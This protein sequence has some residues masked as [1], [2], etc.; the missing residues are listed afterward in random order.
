MPYKTK[1]DAMDIRCSNSVAALAVLITGGVCAFFVPAASAGDRIEFSAP[2]VPLAVPQAEVEAKSPARFIGS[3]GGTGG[4]MGGGEMAAPSQYFVVKP[5][6]REKDDWGLGPLL[7]DDPERHRDDDWFS[8]RTD[9]TQPT[10]SNKLNLKLGLNPNA[11]DNAPQ[12]R[13]DSGYDSVQNDARFGAQNG[14][15][16]DASRFGA[17]IGLGDDNSRFGSQMGFDRDRDKLGAQNETD[18]EYSKFGAKNSMD[19]NNAKLSTKT[20]F[21][22]NAKNGSERDYSKF[23]AQYGLDKE[24]GQSSGRFGRG[25]SNVGADLFSTKDFSHD[26]SGTDG[27]GSLRSMPSASETRPFSGDGYGRTSNPWLG[28]DP[29]Q[30]AAPPSYP[31]FSSLDNSQGRPADQPAG[32]GQASLRAWDPG[33]SAVLPPRNYSN[34]E[35]INSSHFVAHALPATIPMPKR[36]GDPH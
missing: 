32:L 25:F 7:G 24:D 26:A 28:Q 6:H 36:P 3:P 27:F 33:A 8:S 19:K 10:N 2:A 22:G 29:T 35:Q 17:K 21:D 20:G 5:K 14:L 13:Y 15:D 4:F 31:G 18:R 11:A 23:G 30:S 9:S 12:Q 34:P 1:L 16:R